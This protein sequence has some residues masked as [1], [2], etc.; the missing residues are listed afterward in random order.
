MTENQQNQLLDELQKN[1]R[2]L[3]KKYN[4]QLKIFFDK[5]TTMVKIQ[6]IEK[7]A[8]EHLH[9]NYPRFAH[10][11][12]L[13]EKTR[14]RDIM[15]HQQA[16]CLIAH[17]CKHTKTYIGQHFKRDHSS[18]INSIT[19]A[20]NYLW[21]KDKTFIEIYNYINNKI[22]NYVGTISNNSEEQD[23]TESMSIVVFNE[24]E[25]INF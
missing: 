14:I 20:E 24:G 9:T 10:I 11:K 2:S 25:N 17:N 18:A 4:I 5:K 15:I 19:Q 1:V 7:F 6:D 3:I 13:S 8:L 23:N 12:T 22:N 21:S 16:A